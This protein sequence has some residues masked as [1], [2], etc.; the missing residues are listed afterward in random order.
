MIPLLD[1]ILPFWILAVIASVVGLGGWLLYEGWKIAMHLALLATQM[2][3]P[4]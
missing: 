4:F 3:V 1:R 2:E